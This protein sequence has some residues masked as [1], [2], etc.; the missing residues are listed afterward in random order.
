MISQDYVYNKYTNEYLNLIETADGSISLYSQLYEESF[1][2]ING[3]LTE[4]YEKFA[5]PANIRNR[6]INKP[7][8]ILDVCFGLGY[9]TG[10]IIEVNVETDF[11]ARNENFQKFCSDLS[12]TCICQ[13][14]RSICSIL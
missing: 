4:A 6:F 1:H 5:V 2:D 10:V 14:S 12:L 13:K 7:I 11:V 8:Y 3:A 9:N